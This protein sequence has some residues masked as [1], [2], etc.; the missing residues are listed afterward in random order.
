MSQKCPK[1]HKRNSFSFWVLTED[2]LLCSDYSWRR[3]R[4]FCDAEKRKRGQK[5]TTQNL[6]QLHK[7]P[8]EWFVQK[9]SKNVSLFFKTTFQVR[10]S[11]WTFEFHF[12]NCLLRFLDQWK[13]AK[14]NIFCYFLNFHRVHENHWWD[15]IVDADGMMSQWVAQEGT[16]HD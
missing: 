1:S 6:L 15:P 11:I 4:S 10:K 3:E 9:K 7:R 5:S 12:C 13:T 14:E 16:S 8:E 2:F